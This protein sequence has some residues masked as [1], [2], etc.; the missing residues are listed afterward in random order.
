MAL[1]GR[2]I[3]A[4]I[5]VICAGIFYTQFTEAHVDTW[6]EVMA[7]IGWSGEPR[8]MNALYQDPGYSTDPEFDGEIED[9]G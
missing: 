9:G 7:A 6:N 2:L 8:E 3:A 1:I 5:F 4:A